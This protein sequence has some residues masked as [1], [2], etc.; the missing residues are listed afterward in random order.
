MKTLAGFVLLALLT[1]GC[2]GTDKA[3]NSHIQ[4]PNDQPLGLPKGAGG[5]V[6]N[7]KQLKVVKGQGSDQKLSGVEVK[8]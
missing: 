6:K 7:I 4:T 1:T 3:D 8:K 5:D 2:G